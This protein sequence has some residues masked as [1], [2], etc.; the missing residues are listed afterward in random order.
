[1]LAIGIGIIVFLLTFLFCNFMTDWKGFSIIYGVI[2]G[3]LV[4]FCVSY[5]MT[6]PPRNP[7][8]TNLIIENITQLEVVKA[9]QQYWIYQDENFI[10]I[11]DKDL[12]SYVL[13]DENKVN[14][15][16]EVYKI[17]YKKP[18]LW[19]LS[20][21]NINNYAYYKIVMEE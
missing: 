9:K 1:M 6:A 8:D 11:F 16:P 13:Y 14:N 17:K 2:V 7:E 10:N 18:N 5:S 21:I 4:F 20:F 19:W 3:A 15:I 12:Q